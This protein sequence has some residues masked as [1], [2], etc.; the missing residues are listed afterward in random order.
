MGA[1]AAAGERP[2]ID[3]AV[4]P[5]PA[6]PRIAG[7]GAD[8]ASLRVGS[9]GRLR[10]WWL[11][12]VSAAAKARAQAPAMAPYSIAL[13]LHLLAAL[14]FVGT[15][16]F[17]VLI[18]ERVRR[19]VPKNAMHLVEAGI[20]QVARRIMPWVLLALYGSGASMAW[21]YRGALASPL[22]SGFALMLTLKIALA[23]GV[24]GHFAFAMIQMRRG[25]L[26]GS[27]SRRLH[28]SLFWHMVGIVLLAKA[29]FHLSW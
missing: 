17:E 12:H 11:I 5:T 25:R 14:L 3:A 29:M 2:G 7:E 15:V 9:V 19:H 8:A 16:F 13:V 4:A 26:R 24:A 18:L 10:P 22:S 1:R 27:L 6:L 20:G 21:Q 23:L 28:L